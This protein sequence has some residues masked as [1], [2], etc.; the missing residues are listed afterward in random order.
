MLLGLSHTNRLIILYQGKITT[1]NVLLSTI[2]SIIVVFLTVA[3]YKCDNLGTE[4][5]AVRAAKADL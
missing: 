1:A 4:K 3:L 2:V 5:A